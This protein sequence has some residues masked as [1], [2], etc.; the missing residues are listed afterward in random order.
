MMM[1][2]QLTQLIISISLLTGRSVSVIKINPG[3]VTIYLS[4]YSTY[5]VKHK[6]HT[7]G[8]VSQKPCISTEV[9]VGSGSI[10]MIIGAGGY[11]GGGWGG[12]SSYRGN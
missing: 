2:C 4:Y 8:C 10:C 11:G 9:S 3:D 5:T 6:I 12:A 1:V 7:H